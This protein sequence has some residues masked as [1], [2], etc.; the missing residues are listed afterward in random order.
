MVPVRMQVEGS[1]APSCVQGVSGFGTNFAPFSKLLIRLNRQVT[2]DDGRLRA[3]VRLP[4]GVRRQ[5]QNPYGGLNVG[6]LEIE[7]PMPG[8]SPKLRFFLYG[9]EGDEPVC[10]YRSL[11]V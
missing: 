9:H 2:T 6:I 11:Q 10:I 7:T 8:A 4:P 3:K 1:P 5:R